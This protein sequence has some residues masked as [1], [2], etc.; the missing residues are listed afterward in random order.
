MVVDLA[1]TIGATPA[2]GRSTWKH[3]DRGVGLSVR[4]G[5]VVSTTL[6][7]SVFQFD[8]S[9]GLEGPSQVDLPKS[10]SAKRS[11]FHV[12]AQ[13]QDES[14]PMSTQ[15]LREKVAQVKLV[16][17]LIRVIA[18]SKPKGPTST[19]MIRKG[20]PCAACIAYKG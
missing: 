1:Q 17:T 7:T 20:P 15:D 5:D 12:L 13:E 14:V 16:R 9:I 2:A 18:W 8:H 19:H 4:S 10:S 11:W 3:V 6:T